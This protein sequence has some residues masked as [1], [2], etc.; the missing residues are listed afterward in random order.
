MRSLEHI[1]CSGI[2]NTMVFDE[3]L[4]PLN[5]GRAQRLFNA[6]QR[7]ALAVKWG[8]CAFPGCERPPSWT[9]HTT[10]SSGHRDKGKTNIDDGVPLCKHHHLLVH[11]NGWEIEH[12]AQGQYWLI[13]PKSHDRIRHQSCCNP[14]T[15]THARPPQRRTT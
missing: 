3:N 1:A 4:Q 10:S 12:D 14:K 7:E 15:G 9:K 11:N 5:L 8:G 2:V 13:P 6:Q